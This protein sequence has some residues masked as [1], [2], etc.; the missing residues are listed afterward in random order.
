MDDQIARVRYSR[1]GAIEEMALA[2]RGIELDMWQRGRERCEWSIVEARLDDAVVQAGAMAAPFVAVGAADTSE[3]TFAF[4]TSGDRAWTINGHTMQSAEIGVLGRG[5]EVTS[6][7]TGPMQWAAVQIAPEKLYAHAESIAGLGAYFRQGEAHLL[8]PQRAHVAAL[9]CVLAT[10]TALAVNRPD[11]LREPDVRHALE[12]ELMHALVRCLGVMPG[13]LRSNHERI[14][15]RVLAYLEEH[16]RDVI[17]VADLCLATGSSERW[18]REALQAV[19]GVSPM[20]LLKLRRLNQV[21]RALLAAAPGESSV[22]ELAMSYGFFDLGRFAISYR[23][24]F[25]ELP[26]E[27]LQKSKR[28]YGT[29]PTMPVQY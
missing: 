19:Y 4:R 26:S 15:Q 11:A 17:Y 25:G 6:T 27:T 29:V 7:T 1:P 18:L 28:R 22:T 13:P 12:A 5:V 9:L 8:Q 16:D 3:L 23:Q 21:H 10:T 2:I 24:I 14:A 20:R